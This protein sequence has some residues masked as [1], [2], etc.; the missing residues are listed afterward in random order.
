M[1]RFITKPSTVNAT[2]VRSAAGSEDL[3]TALNRDCLCVTVNRDTLRCDLDADGANADLYDKILATR[4]NLFSATAVFVTPQQVERMHEIIRAVETVVALPAY[5]EAVLAEAPEIARFDP[6]PRGVFMGYDFH[7]GPAGPQLIE[8]NTNAGGALLNVALQRAQSAC[9]ETM[10]PLIPAPARVGALDDTF[11][12]MF[13][14]EWQLQRG[15]QPLTNIAIVDDAPREQYLY[16]EFLLFERL[17]RRHGLKAVIADPAEL[18]MHNSKLWH[19]NQAIDLVYNRLTDFALQE[20]RHALL[21]QAYLEGG[22]VLT[23]HPRAHALYA[24]KHNLVALTDDARLRAW[25]VPEPV[26][27]TLLTGI[28]HTV[29]VTAAGAE[30]LWAQRRTLFFKPA[31]G[32]GAKAAYRGDKLTR[33]VWDELVSGR[34]V[35]QEQIAPSQRRL[36]QDG[37]ETSLKLDI[38]NYVYDGEVQLLAARLYQGQTTNFRTPGGGFAPVFCPSPEGNPPANLIACGTRKVCK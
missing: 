1:N 7:L 38:R 35:A 23:P 20:P 34:Y 30:A 10:K 14:R 25:Q 13:L 28:P 33:R 32:Y 8:I 15:K 36:R 37:T 29:R 26:V 6:G 24:D 18:R 9:G 19:E 17:F 3:A 21:R 27:H 11:R 5:R 12:Q 2:A 22:V 16:P 31:A 4:P